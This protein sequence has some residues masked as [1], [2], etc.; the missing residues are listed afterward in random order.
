M[1]GQRKSLTGTVVSDKMEKTVVVLVETTSRHPLYHKIVKRSKRFLAHDDRLNAKPGDLVRI[2]E[3]RPLSR[4]KR[5]RVAEIIQRGEEAEIAPQEI[6]AEYLEER[7]ERQAEAAAAARASAAEA[8][9]KAEAEAEA[10][11]PEASAAVAEAPAGEPTAEVGAPSEEVVEA[12][13]PAEEE[14]PQA[15]VD[16]EEPADTE[17]QEERPEEPEEP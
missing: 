13:E 11:E 6:G 5:W 4:H 16:A 17:E 14:E 12:E 3:T 15:A 7:R 2:M 8:H 10:E 1:A 9:I